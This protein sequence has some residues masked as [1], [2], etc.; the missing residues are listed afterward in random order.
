MNHVSTHTGSS[1]KEEVTLK[2]SQIMR[3]LLL[4][5]H[6]ITKAAKRHGFGDTM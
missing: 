5:L 1:G 3:E 6:D 4:A 2:I